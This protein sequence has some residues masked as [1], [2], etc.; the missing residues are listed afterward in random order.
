MMLMT[1]HGVLIRIPVDGIS[2]TGRNT[3]GVRLIRLHDDEEVATVAKIDPDPE[4]EENETESSSDG[5]S[6]EDDSGHDVI[7]DA[8]NNPDALS[9]DETDSDEDNT[10]NE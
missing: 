10:D 9:E 4:E 1:I 7:E 5:R 2:E 6:N 3:Q 8:Q